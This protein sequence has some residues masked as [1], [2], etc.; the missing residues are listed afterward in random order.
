MTVEA[1][2][3]LTLINRIVLASSMEMRLIRGYV[4]EGENPSLPKKYISCIGQQT[5]VN[6]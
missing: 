1:I 2:T 6:L 5:R 3:L 4:L